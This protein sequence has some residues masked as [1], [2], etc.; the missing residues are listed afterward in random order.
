M[1][2][3]IKCG[4]LVGLYLMLVLA[5][6]LL[7]Y[8][9]TPDLSMEAN[10]LVAVLG[11]G[12]KSLFIVNLLFF[13]LFAAMA[14]FTF[15]KY[16]TI[17]AGCSRYTQYVSQIAFR[18]P[19]KF[20]W[21]LYKFPK[22][23]RI[24][25]AYIGYAFTYGMIAARIVIVLEWLAATFHFNLEIYN[26]FC[27]AYLWGRPDIVLGCVVALAAEFVWFYWEFRKQRGMPPQ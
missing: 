2:Q 5:D 16:Q 10:P 8:I 24:N 4:V 21:I 15:V 1:K 6:G 25:L 9:N 20:V 14:W 19:D 17:Y 23:W 18:R 27:I 11:L 22:N 7:T 26:R 12:W 13:I 3:K